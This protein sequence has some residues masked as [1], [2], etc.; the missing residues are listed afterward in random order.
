MEL[1]TTRRATGTQQQKD[2]YDEDVKRPVKEVVLRKPDANGNYINNGD[3]SVKE[4][5][6]DETNWK[7]LTALE[8]EAEASIDNNT[9]TVKT[10]KEGTVDYSVQLV[11]ADLPFEKGATYQVQFDA[12]ASADREMGV[13]VKAP[14]HGYMSYMPH[15][16]VQ[17]T[18]QKQTYT[19]TFKMGDASDA[20]GR[21]EYN[22]G[23]KGSTADIYISNVSVKKTEEADP[24]EKEKK[25]VLANGNYV[26]N[27]SFQEGD[28]HLG[29]ILGVS[30][31]KKRKNTNN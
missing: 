11:Q 18:T 15:Q 3:F 6:S 30:F 24:N 21:L 28:K 8:G 16:D 17:L 5:L 14:D 23:A 31:L 12:Y 13:D 25:T 20:N 1:N 19:Y 2:S 7:F 10:A 26:Y 27:G 4:E 29:Y 22:M 9:M